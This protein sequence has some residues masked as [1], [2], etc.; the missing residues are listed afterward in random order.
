M[1]IIQLLGIM[2]IFENNTRTILKIVITF[3][4]TE[5]IWFFIQAYEIY[6]KIVFVL[7]II[8]FGAKC[9]LIFITMGPIGYHICKLILR[10][11]IGI[12]DWFLNFIRFMS[13]VHEVALS[14]ISS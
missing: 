2:N 13:Y 10:V 1:N 5:G 7:K 12:R 6:S 9:I 11:L 8:Q 3:L 14:N 4:L